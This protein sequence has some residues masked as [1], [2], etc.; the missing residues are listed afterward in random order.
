MSVYLSF[1]NNRYLLAL[2]DAVLHIFLQICLSLLILL[3]VIIHVCDPHN[4]VGSTCVLTINS[5]VLFDSSLAKKNILLPQNVFSAFFALTLMSSF[6]PRVWSAT[7][8]IPNSVFWLVHFILFTP[9]TVVTN[10]GGGFL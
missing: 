3:F 2:P 7:I 5:F 9:S 10:S 6:V 1:V 8:S 4:S